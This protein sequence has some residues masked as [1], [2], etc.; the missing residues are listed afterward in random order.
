M[1][2]RIAAA[3]LSLP[4]GLTRFGRTT[5]R[6]SGASSDAS[7]CS[8][9]QGRSNAARNRSTTSTFAASDTAAK[10]TARRRGLACKG[11]GVDIIDPKLAE[12]IERLSSPA[13]PL[14]AE[15][16]EETRQTLS[17]PGM[18]SGPIAG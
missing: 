15:L 14:L 9:G 11:S 12:Y 6:T 8:V 10:L 17:S 16:A 5:M 13:D 18:L 1:P 7:S 2:A 4:F 3:S